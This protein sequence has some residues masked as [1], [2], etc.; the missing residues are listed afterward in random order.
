MRDP[1][2]PLC[3]LTIWFLNCIWHCWNPSTARNV[4]HLMSATVVSPSSPLSSLSESASFTGCAPCSK[5][6][7]LPDHPSDPKLPRLFHSP[8]KTFMLVIHKFIFVTL[9]SYCRGVFCFLRIHVLVC[10]LFQLAGAIE[11]FL[12]IGCKLKWHISPLPQSI[13][14]KLRIAV[15]SLSPIEECERPCV[16]NGETKW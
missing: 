11:L 9:I 4:P 12:A 6:D 15:L 3:L 2:P 1:K 10:S 14:K 5:F 16:L 13:T 8:R 7:S